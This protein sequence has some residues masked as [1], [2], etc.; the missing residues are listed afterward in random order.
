MLVAP[1]SDVRRE[2]GNSNS[3]A[4]QVKRRAGSARVK[5]ELVLGLDTLTGEEECGLCACTERRRTC[6]PCSGLCE[7]G[8]SRFTI[9]YVARATACHMRVPVKRHASH[10]CHRVM[11][12]LM[13]VPVARHASHSWHRDASYARHEETRTCID[14]HSNS[15]QLLWATC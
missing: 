4:C 6:A 12:R 1:P 8:A 5:L 11:A 14:V 13:R 7:F 10:S 2:R 15:V 9:A 3:D